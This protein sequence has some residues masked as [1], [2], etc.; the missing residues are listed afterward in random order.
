MSLKEAYKAGLKN[1]MGT[2]ALTG[3]QC[4]DQ[5]DTACQTASALP[6]SSDKTARCQSRLK[7]R[8]IPHPDNRL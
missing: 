3:C 4:T 8:K 1:R 7:G 6:S 5:T 2:D